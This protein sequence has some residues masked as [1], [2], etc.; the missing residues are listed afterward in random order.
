MNR[1]LAYRLDL[2]LDALKT[3]AIDAIRDILEKANAHRVTLNHNVFIDCVNKNAYSET[4]EVYM[5][6]QCFIVDSFDESQ[7]EELKYIPVASLL[8]ILRLIEEGEYD[9]EEHVEDKDL[10]NHIQAQEDAHFDN[11]CQQNNI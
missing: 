3:E 10:S 11:F 5:T 7:L 4:K 1:D 6:G 9:I 2:R 8:S